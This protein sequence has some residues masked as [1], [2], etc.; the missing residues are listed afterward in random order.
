MTRVA[1]GAQDALAD[2]SLQ[3]LWPCAPRSAPASTPL[4]APPQAATAAVRAASGQAPQPVTTAQSLQA[5][6]GNQP[7]RRSSSGE[8]GSSGGSGASGSS[9]GSGASTGS[10]ASGRVPAAASSPAAQ[11]SPP[12]AAARP[13]QPLPGSQPARRSSSGESRSSAGSGTSGSS[14]GAAR[15]GDGGGGSAALHAADAADGGDLDTDDDSDSEDGVRLGR[16]EALQGLSEGSGALPYTASPSR[17]S[18]AQHLPSSSMEAQAKSPEAA[19]THAAALVGSSGAPRPPVRRSLFRE[20]VQAR[21][22]PGSVAAGAAAPRAS[23]I[24]WGA[25][26]GVPGV[27]QG[28]RG[29]AA[30]DAWALAAHPGLGDSSFGL[31]CTPAPLAVLPPDLSPPGGFKLAWQLRPR[32]GG[33]DTKPAAAQ[34]QGA[35]AAGA[36]G[37]GPGPGL[38]PDQGPHSHAPASF[39]RSSVSLQPESSVL[40]VPGGMPASRDLPVRSPPCTRIAGI[41]RTGAHGCLALRCCALLL[42]TCPT[43]MLC[44]GGG[45]CCNCSSGGCAC[46]H[47]CNRCPRRGRPQP[48]PLARRQAA[49]AQAAA[50]APAPPLALQCL[51]TAFMLLGY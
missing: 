41:A 8:S 39:V 6:S 7:A 36:A 48:R 37:P 4:A 9:G 21:S 3:P 34:A 38:N 29:G 10:D 14:D 11:L 27:H 17:A 28:D 13:P 51:D 42:R 2:R 50:G 47:E 45:A 43:A 30:A 1:A 24:D 33:P 26:G 40:V 44:I 31:D 18:A 32:G 46:R 49:H 23:G 25:R 15:S 35:A 12:G 5:P 22:S 20:D 19:L 16:R